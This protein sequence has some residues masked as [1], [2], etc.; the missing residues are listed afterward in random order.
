M[1]D[2]DTSPQRS[3]APEALEA[4]REAAVLYQK[5]EAL[6]RAHTRAHAAASSPKPVTM[7][8]PGL[9]PYSEIALAERFV[10]RHADEL[11]YV[12]EWKSWMLFDGSRWQRERTALAFELAR[13]VAR[14][15]ATEAAEAK[16]NGANNIATARMRASIIALAS[17]DRRIA[18]TADQWDTS[19]WLLNTPEG[20]V[21]LR[22]GEIEPSRAD[23]YLTRMTSVAP[24]FDCPIPLWTAFLG[25]IF[26]RDG[27]P[28]EAL[29]GYLQR[30]LGYA[31][32]GDTSEHAMWFAYG[33]GSNG[34]SV[35]LDTVAGIMAD[36]HRTAAIETF[37]ATNGDRHPT[38]LAS[39][40]GARLVTA[41][42]TEEGRR[43]AEARIK[44]LTGGDTIAARFMRQDFFEFKPV[45]K[46]AIAGN[47]KPALRAV[48]EAIRRRFN[49]IP[50]AETIPK[51]ERDLELAA[52]L[53]A[54]WPGILAWMLDGC[55]GWREE[56]LDRPEAVADATASYLEAEDDVAAWLEECCDVGPRHSD[57]A[58]VLYNSWKTWAE[59]AG[60]HP[61]SSK[62]FANT[63]ESRGFSR[64]KTKTGR[65][66]E[67]LMV[68]S[69][70]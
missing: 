23:Y 44:T 1:D 19:P 36:Y 53:R 59:R 35:L 5:E 21:D 31:L 57:G 8:H 68:R 43:W 3:S 54:E 63:L 11:R 14:E 27:K 28:D 7:H 25:R 2:H 52:K 51:A 30:V 13:R 22:T 56:G 39:L 29:I 38:E 33:T 58:T 62:A 4:L 70:G 20:V 10:D 42:E 6:T 41:I 46:L 66:Y 67:G 34:K 61:G 64:R 9:P 32:T 48:D 26:R 60:A 17:G 49:L 69:T 37:T 18:A 47:H 12:A 24:D 55:L 65:L 45:F 15:A 16:E 40:R 50:F